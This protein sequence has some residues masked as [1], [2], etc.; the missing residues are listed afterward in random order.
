MNEIVNK[1]GSL[2]CNMIMSS[3]TKVKRI[4]IF[5]H[6]YGAGGTDLLPLATVIYRG[7]SHTHFVLP[8]G[9]LSLPSGFP[10]SDGRAWWPID[11]NHIASTIATGRLSEFQESVPE[12]LS[13]A[14]RK[15][16]ASINILA[17]RYDVPYSQFILGGF[18]QGAM[19][20]TDVALRLEEPSLALCILSGSLICKIMWSDRAK[21]RKN[22]P[23]FQ[24]HGRMDPIL[25]Y[26]NA[27][28]LKE[29]LHECGLRPEFIPF[30]DQHTIPHDVA[31]KLARFLSTTVASKV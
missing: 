8:H 5:C 30:D 29:L 15:L 1:I 17:N 6:G 23:I 26:S 22:L 4:C 11:I 14:R 24:S 25:P 21:R 2:T 28:A 7:L 9:P 31:K 27:V 18:S 13:S 12:G 16:I 20:V 19:L 10:Y 3:N